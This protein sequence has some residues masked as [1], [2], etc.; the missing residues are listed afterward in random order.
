MQHTGNAAVLRVQSAHAVMVFAEDAE[1]LHH[2]QWIVHM[3]TSVLCIKTFWAP[4]WHAYTATLGM[5]THGLCSHSNNKTYTPAC[6]AIHAG[7]HHQQALH[8]GPIHTQLPTTQN[9]THANHTPALLVMHS[10]LQMLSHHIP[11]V[12]TARNKQTTMQ[13]SLLHLT[14][15]WQGERSQHSVQGISHRLAACCHLI[16]ASNIAVL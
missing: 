4:K 14:Q 15:L 1:H 16:D 6:E 8:T 13:L 3:H 10:L 12:Q 5:F 9:H 11:V 7:L 2:K